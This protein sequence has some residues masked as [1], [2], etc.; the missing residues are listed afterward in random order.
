MSVHAVTGRGPRTPKYEVVA[1]RLKHKVSALEPHGMLP[2]ERDLMEEYGVSRSTIR[3]A[4][5]VLMRDGFVY[6]IQG[7]GTYV[8]DPA[9]VAKTLRLTGFSQDMRQRGLKPSSVILHSGTVSASVQL[10][11]LLG[12]PSGTTLVV[13]DRLRLADDQPMALEHVCLVQALTTD[14][15]LDPTQSLYRQLETAGITVERANQNIDA[16]NLDPTQAKLLDQAVGAAALR[17]RRVTYTDRGQALEH[18]ET[19]YRADRYSFEFVIQAG[20]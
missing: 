12:V 7:S 13:I 18:A 20:L 19:I 6:N 14:V 5:A 15:R 4:I 17:A 9:V 2:T 3:Q 16:V 11:A 1:N 10:A 8:G